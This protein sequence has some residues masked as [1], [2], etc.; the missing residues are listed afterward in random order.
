MIETPPT[1]P[2]PTPQPVPTPEPQPVPTPIPQ[3]VPTP[4]PQ[5]VPNPE[6]QPQPIPKLS[7]LI[8]TNYKF[9]L[10]INKCNKNLRQIELNQK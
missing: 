2:N 7:N 9:P 10:N 5:P 1:R 8:A 4:E 6:P 3:P